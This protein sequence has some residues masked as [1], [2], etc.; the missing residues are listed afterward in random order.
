MDKSEIL[1]HIS[2]PSGADDDARYRAQVEAILNFQSHSRE[3]LT[4]RTDE[5]QPCLASSPSALGTS[6][7]PNTNGLSNSPPRIPSQVSKRPASQKDSLGSPI[8]VIPDSQPELTN[9]VSESVHLT[10]SLPSKRPR[11]GSTSALD[12]P[13]SDS[14]RRTEP[15]GNHGVGT[16]ASNVIGTQSTTIITSDDEQGK[17]T[18]EAA[19]PLEKREEKQ[20]LDLTSL[21]IEIKPPPPPISSSPFTT[22]ITST[23]EMLTKH[24]KSHRIYNP[25]KQTRSLDDLE[26]GYWLIHINIVSLLSENLSPATTSSDAGT[27]DIPVFSKFWTF[28]FDFIAKEGRAGWGVWCIAEDKSTPY[29][30]TT[31]PEAHEVR[32]NTEPPPSLHSHT[33]SC[34]SLQLAVKIYAWGEIACHIY[35]LLF[36][37]SERRVR[38]MGAQWRDAR[39]QVVI[40]MP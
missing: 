7:H 6:P 19:N 39:G 32:G 30:D 35:L 26:R 22:H 28:L 27:W 8:S 31:S 9:L 11:V 12:E 1:V 17:E 34:K 20:W 40:Q 24:L 37:A 3:L 38:K 25:T 4:L 15:A 36:L 14:V 5:A 21:P 10:S 18:T 13:Q 33:A 29:R 16:I 2:A 23:L